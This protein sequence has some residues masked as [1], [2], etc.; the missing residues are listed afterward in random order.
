MHPAYFA[1]AMATGIVS[2]GCHEVGLGTLASALYGLNVFMYVL[3]WLATALRVAFHPRA[4][5]ADWTDHQRAPGFFSW[6]A[7]TCVLGAQGL[8]LGGSLQVALG[9]W[10]LAL[11]LWAGCTYAVF[12]ALS[13]SAEKPSLEGGIN[14][15]WLLAVV[16][17]QGLCVLGCQ[18]LPGRVPA[19]AYGLGLA[20]LW[21][22]GGTLYVWLSGLILYRTLFFRLSPEEVL[23]NYWIT[24][25]AAA[26]TTLAGT[27]LVAAAPGH[28]V[29]VELRP[30]V[31]GL[32]LLAWATAS[33]WIPLL[34]ALGVW[35]HVV[36]RVRLAYDPLYWGLVFPLGMYG[37]CTL[38]L[39]AT[40]GPGFL[41]LVGTGSCLAGLAAWVLTFGGMLVRL[42]A[43]EA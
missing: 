36:R 28:P 12:T 6:A 25:G 11:L 29:L 27:A 35:R 7:A 22:A 37:V 16:A 20:A 32:T 38:H 5:L 21:L 15:G 24:M 39:Y 30:F 1:L 8:A 18:V 19:G 31:E 2:I 42:A 40:F 33:W 9:L 17:T 3:L 4:F 14:G 34:V 26:I 23:P 41:R 10:G 43:L 13:V